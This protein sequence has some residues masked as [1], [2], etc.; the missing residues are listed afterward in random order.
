[1]GR[2][3]DIVALGFNT[4]PIVES[5]ARSGWSVAA[6]DVFGDEDLRASADPVL[7]LADGSGPLT[8]DPRRIVAL[9][10]ELGRRAGCSTFLP[11][12]GFDAAPKSLAPLAGEVLS[13][14]IA[15][16]RRAKD[17]SALARLGL[18]LPR[19]VRARTPL[20]VR[21]AARSLG[22]PCVTK[23]PAG[24]AGRGVV[25]A[26]SEADLPR[27]V[28]PGGL[29]VQEHV[30]GPALSASFLGDGHRAVLAGTNRQLLGSPW[31]GSSGFLFCG[32][33]SPVEVGHE[34][35]ERL[36][37]LGTALARGLGLCG[38]FGLDL[39]VRDGEIVVFEVNPRPQ[40][41][42]DTLDRALGVS[43]GDLHV[44]ACR[45]A[46]PEA[47]PA[48]RGECWAK[49]I[50]YALHDGLAPALGDDVADRPAPLTPFARGE[51]VCTVLARG[52]GPG[53]ALR[54]VRE[55]ARAVYRLLG[56]GPPRAA[57]LTPT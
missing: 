42:V 19:T 36:A 56:R 3:V 16:L 20:S 13:S 15:S 50:V 57:G 2:A 22:F 14:P 45:G 27:R 24:S 28:P 9:A 48:P 44:R 32:C 33:V 38:S 51:P 17:V 47:L 31:L 37:V 10:L 29:L 26:G 46:L 52:A 49:A 18:P 30:P 25:L 35:R 54:A 43:L 4:R 34:V 6:A 23:P 12:S 53:D 7:A 1:M 39:T 8:Y 40:S 11:V 55:R 41:T 5:L 21:R